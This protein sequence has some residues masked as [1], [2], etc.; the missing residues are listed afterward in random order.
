[1]LYPQENLTS[2]PTVYGNPVFFR[3]YFFAGRR[4]S[5]FTPKMRV[6]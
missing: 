6:V 1:M 3:D 5:I 4:S 2:D